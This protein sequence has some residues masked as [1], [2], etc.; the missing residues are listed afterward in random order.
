MIP[1]I[2]PASSEGVPFNISSGPASF[3]TTALGTPCG[4]ARSDR[5]IPLQH[6]FLINRC[7]HQCGILFCF[8]KPEDNGV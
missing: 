5:F 7:S 6:L 4:Y 3:R 8:P 2:Y 1:S